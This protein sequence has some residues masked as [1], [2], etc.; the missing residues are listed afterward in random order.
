MFFDKRSTFARGTAAGGA[1]LS[2]LF[3]GV[4]RREAWPTTCATLTVIEV[5]AYDNKNLKERYIRIPLLILS[6]PVRASF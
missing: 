1:V 3:L 4:P 5:W 2:G 6:G